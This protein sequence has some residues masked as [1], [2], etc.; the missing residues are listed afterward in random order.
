MSGEK[1]ASLA[2][3]ADIPD[4]PTAAHHETGY[5]FFSGGFVWE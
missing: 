4:A 3:G 2:T 5:D 1:I